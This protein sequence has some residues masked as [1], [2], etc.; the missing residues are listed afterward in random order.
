MLGSR[1]KMVLD[2]HRGREGR[3]Q[4]LFC[5]AQVQGSRGQ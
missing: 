2:A 4:V 3:N 5:D 1:G